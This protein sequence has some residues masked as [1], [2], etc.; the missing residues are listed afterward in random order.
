MIMVV[1]VF[2]AQHILTCVW[3][4]IGIEEK[5]ITRKGWFTPNLQN[6]ENIQIYV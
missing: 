3:V 2:Y 6:K 1:T 5:L 4:H